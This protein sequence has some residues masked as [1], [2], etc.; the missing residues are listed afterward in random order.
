[1]TATTDEIIAEVFAAIDDHYEGTDRDRARA[2]AKRVLRGTTELETYAERY[3]AA[4][5]ARDT[6]M[7]ELAGAVHA[8]VESDSEN[9]I[10]KRTGLT[11]VTVRRM[12][13]KTN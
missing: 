8:A 13:G 6:A 10:A 11:R 3:H 2:A 12:F 7:A 5:A 9:R 4:Q 1:M